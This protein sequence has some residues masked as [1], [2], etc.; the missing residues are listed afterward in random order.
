TS[1]A[2]LEIAR[3]PG[4]ACDQL[5]LPVTNGIRRTIV[6]VDAQEL[7]TDLATVGST[8]NKMH[9]S[10]STSVILLAADLAAAMLPLPLRFDFVAALAKP[11]DV[12]MLAT[13]LRVAKAGDAA[14]M[15][16]DGN[17]EHAHP[18]R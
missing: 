12:R 4:Q 15:D 18:A 8:L 14:G 6:I 9:H 13:A 16:E 5:A 10:T 17:V 3:S 7:Q 1:R 11:A 2:T